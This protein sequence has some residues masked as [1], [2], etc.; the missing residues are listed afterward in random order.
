MEGQSKTFDQWT[1]EYAKHY[2]PD[3]G[4]KTYR[5][6][7]V[8]FNTQPLTDDNHLGYSHLGQ[9]KDENRK[10]DRSQADVGNALETLGHKLE[11][12][13]Q[14]GLFIVANAQ[15]DN[16]LS[17]LKGMK[18]KGKQP[19]L[20]PLPKEVAARGEL[21]ILVLHHLVGIVLIQVK[22]VGFVDSWQPT[23]EQLQAAIEKKGKEAYNQLDRDEAVLHHVLKDL[24]LHCNVHKVVAMPYVKRKYLEKTFGSFASGADNLDAPTM[25]R[26]LCLDDM[27]TSEAIWSWW[28]G[29]A[30]DSGDSMLTDHQLKSIVGRYCGL[31]STVSVWCKSSPR[32]EVRDVAEAA[33]EVGAR[34]ASIV[35]TKDQRDALD[36]QDHCVFLYG[37]PGTGK[38]VM[39][40]VKA[41]KWLKD[42]HDVCV[43]NPDF[44]RLG[45][46]VGHYIHDSIFQWLLET[47]RESD[48]SENSSG[49]SSESEKSKGRTTTPSASSELNAG[50]QGGAVSKN[51]KPL[52]G[53]PL[54]NSDSAK[55]KRCTANFT[56][57]ND[58]RPVDQQSTFNNISCSGDCKE[59]TLFL[60]GNQ[61]FCSPTTCPTNAQL[62]LRD[63]TSELNNK[64]H[65]LSVHSDSSR[66]LSS[67]SLSSEAD[68]LRECGLGKVFR[69]DFDFGM[70]FKGEK[71]VIQKLLQEIRVKV[72]STVP[73]HFLWDEFYR[74]DCFV[75][76]VEN[77][78]KEFDSSCI[79]CAEVSGKM[80]PEYFTP[81]LLK[82]VLR[83]PPSVQALL[84]RTDPNV[85]YTKLYTDDSTLNG[86]PTDGFRPKLIEHQFH[87]ATSPLD[88]CQ[89]ADDLLKF[90]RH[91]LKLHFEEETNSFDHCPQRQGEITTTECD[92]RGSLVMDIKSLQAE[93]ENKSVQTPYIRKH[94]F[95]PSPEQSTAMAVAKDSAEAFSQNP[96]PNSLPIP[97]LKKKRNLCHP[98]RIKFNDI[99]VIF[100]YPRSCL[101]RTNDLL[102]VN[103]L[104]EDLHHNNIENSVFYRRMKDAGLPAV[105]RA[106]KADAREIALPA[107]DRVLFSVTNAVT[108]LERKVIVYVPCE[109]TTYSYPVPVEQEKGKLK[110][111]ESTYGQSVFHSKTSNQ[112]VS[113]CK[114]FDEQFPRKQ[115]QITIQEKTDTV[116][117]SML[118][119]PQN[120]KRISRN[121][122]TDVTERVPLHY[123]MSSYIADEKDPNYPAHGENCD[124][125]QTKSLAK[126]SVT[127][128][129]LS[130]KEW[131]NIHERMLEQNQKGM[132][133][134]ASRCLS[135]FVLIVP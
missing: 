14:K 10:K 96:S 64:E 111:Q 68:S 35:L 45:M 4:T 34:F 131:A 52:T 74:K 115:D 48:S 101:N 13:G 62:Q 128:A 92:A 43:I 47:C 85:E 54:S 67:G 69:V 110:M 117:L 18:L 12:S 55:Q 95:L 93:G 135:I 88:C 77:L 57:S 71:E 61:V 112:P 109:S 116:S 51:M 132:F 100:S 70:N 114:L 32:V 84:K 120:V 7:P 118:E 56:E 16:Y 97:K 17:D 20:P 124:T 63:H 91:E 87:E 8:D 58:T 106:P 82:T 108:G 104:P 36:C 44:G 30:S 33:E 79:W 50:V 19:R 83:C 59:K 24:H 11:S 39:M 89:C 60:S 126:S 94:K 75:P 72:R 65:G 78:K 25:P 15:Y 107:D 113:D 80:I 31:M 5:V 102:I 46:P 103:T 2:Y 41:R 38:S 98:R 133:Y 127:L 21:D 73:C 49:G 1:L 53:N 6:P 9:Q 123:E 26:F 81:V 22:G 27:S 129:S 99:A 86:L 125:Q 121:C 40:I 37:P 42:G 122:S 3:A 28:T 23:K 76:V 90:F 66:S 29:F 130:E 134:A 119:I 105:F